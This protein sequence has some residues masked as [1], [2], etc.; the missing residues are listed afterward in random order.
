MAA[1]PP[2]ASS[3]KRPSGHSFAPTHLAAFYYCL[4]SLIDAGDFDFRIVLVRPAQPRESRYLTLTRNTTEVDWSDAEGST[5]SGS[6]T[7]RRS[8]VKRI[9][10][11]PVV[12]GG[13]LVSASWST[14]AAAGGGSGISASPTCP[15][16]I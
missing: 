9:N 6:L 4:I 3:A 15:R 5:L 2:A 8:G 13:P 1:R 10:S 7:V 14:G 11:V 16:S 12:R